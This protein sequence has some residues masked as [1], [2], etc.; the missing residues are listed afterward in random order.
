MTITKY[1]HACL[2]IEEQGSQL[3]VDPGSFSTYDLPD[4][5]NP[6][7]VVITHAH[8]DHID[9]A[10][11]VS[12]QASH[13]TAPIYSI[14][15]VADTY[16]SI[17][18]EVVDQDQAIKIDQFT[19]DCWLTDHAIIHPDYPKF[20]NMAIM[21]NDDLYYPG[22]SLYK[23]DKTVITLACPTSGPWLITQKMINFIISLSPSK[24][25][26]THDALYSDVG[27]QIQNTWAERAC[28]K[29]NAK[30]QFIKAGEQL[31]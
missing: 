31:S 11:L 15:E 2:V 6:C 5:T 9:E 27:F 21:V 20:K 24:V 3:I 22:D 25:F 1:P 19:I 10:W 26:S 30:W 14:Q 18:F 29:A 7:A 13:P 23:P 17:T 12:F 8:P 28:D 4:P 16:P